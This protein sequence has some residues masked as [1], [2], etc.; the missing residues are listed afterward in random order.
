M[1]MVTSLLLSL[2]GGLTRLTTLALLAPFGRMSCFDRV[3]ALASPVCDARRFGCTREREM[4][5]FVLLGVT[6]VVVAG[7]MF[8]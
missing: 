3:F 7:V 8:L 5:I 1:I 6:T 2:Y 4:G